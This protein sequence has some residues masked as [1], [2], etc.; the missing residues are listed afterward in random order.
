LVILERRGTDFLH[1]DHNLCGLQGSGKRRSWASGAARS[2]YAVP[3]SAEEKS[4]QVDFS[5]AFRAK[6][7]RGK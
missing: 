2:G 5:G 3:A 6:I 1:D 4:G 7:L